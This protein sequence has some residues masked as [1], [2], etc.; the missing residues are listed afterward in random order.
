MILHLPSS[1]L[2]LEQGMSISTRLCE[3]CDRNHI[4]ASTELVLLD[5]H[6]RSTR[7]SSQREE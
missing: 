3:L 5:I 6:S 1:I 2:N 7:M 4:D